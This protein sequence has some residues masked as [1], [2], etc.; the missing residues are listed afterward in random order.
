MVDHGTTAKE[1]MGMIRIWDFVVFLGACV[2]FV[3]VS[4]LVTLALGELADWFRER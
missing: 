1:E 3:A 4:I 2:L